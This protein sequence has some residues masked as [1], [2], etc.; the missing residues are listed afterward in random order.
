MTI[1]YINKNYFRRALLAAHCNANNLKNFR[2][3]ASFSALRN[4]PIDMLKMV[5][6]FEGRSC[7]CSMIFS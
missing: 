7:T 5:F 4:A 6:N 2:F 3:E 1:I